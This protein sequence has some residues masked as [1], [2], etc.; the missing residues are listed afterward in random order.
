MKTATVFPKVFVIE[1]GHR[2]PED[3]INKLKELPV[4]YKLD[5]ISHV[6]SYFLL[7]D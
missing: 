1:H 5:I 4:S 6:N 2:K 7:I 3:F